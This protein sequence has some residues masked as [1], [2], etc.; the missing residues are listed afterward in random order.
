[1][2][3][4]MWEIHPELANLIEDLLVGYI[5]SVSNEVFEKLSGFSICRKSREQSDYGRKNFL[6][7]INKEEQERVKKTLCLFGYI[8]ESAYE[9]DKDTIQ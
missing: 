9:L 1:M 2:R 4:K 8:S 7:C 6:I 5:A 3:V